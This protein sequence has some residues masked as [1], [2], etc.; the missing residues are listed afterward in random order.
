MRG[1]LSLAESSSEDALQ[2]NQALCSAAREVQSYYGPLIS[3][4]GFKFS[5][6]ERELEL[7]ERIAGAGN[8]DVRDGICR[9]KPSQRTDPR[10]QLFRLGN[11]RNLQ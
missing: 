8:R 7:T 10:G 9:G 2:L 4:K 11:S 1:G 5:E 6:G 3:S